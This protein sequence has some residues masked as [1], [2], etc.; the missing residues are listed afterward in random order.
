MRSCD[1]SSDVCSSDLRIQVH[2]TLGPVF[3]AAVDDWDEHKRLLVSF[4][5]SVVLRAGTYRG[6]PM[7][8]HRSHPITT[9]HFV[10]WLEL[11]RATA[12]DI[13]APEPAELLPEYAGRHGRSLRY[14]LGLPEPGDTASTPRPRGWP[15][16]RG[17]TQEGAP[18]W[19]QEVRTGEPCGT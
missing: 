11:W 1:W 19:T 15:R 12:D 6:N 14:G 16:G 9:E 13:L 7:S 2:P 5:T 8:A 10:Q 3:N 18:L 17:P 4:W